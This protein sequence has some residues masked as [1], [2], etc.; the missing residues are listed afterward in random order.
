[1][2]TVPNSAVINWDILNEVVSM[3]EDEPGFSQSLVV[4]YIDQAETT[5]KEIQKEL[6]SG[7]PSLDKLSSLGHFLKGSSASLGLQ[8]MAW[9]CERIQ[10]YKKRANLPSDSSSDASITAMIREGL[11]MAQTEFQ[12]ARKELSKYYN[13]EL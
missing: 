2:P 7:C 12:C 4:Q 1:M 3:D 10:N 11:S 5:F 8:R 6:E 9:A 13:A